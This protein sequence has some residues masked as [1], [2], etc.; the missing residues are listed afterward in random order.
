[1]TLAWATLLGV[2]GAAFFLILAL[3][4]RA[5]GGDL[6]Q[7]AARICYVDVESFRNLIDVSTGILA[8]ASALAKVSQGSLFAYEGRGRVPLG[9]G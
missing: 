2:I 7:I 5:N 9:C 4:S 8:T 1:M 6:D 3:R